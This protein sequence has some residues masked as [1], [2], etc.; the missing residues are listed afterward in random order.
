MAKWY[1]EQVKKYS[2]SA[3]G[4]VT[5]S[6]TG[7]TEKRAEKRSAPET[8]EAEQAGNK[9]QRRSRQSVRVP[10]DDEEEEEEEEEEEQ[11]NDDDDA[12]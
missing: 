10:D 1:L 8:P 2:L 7:A 11:V 9:R 12:E 6:G 5:K 3:P 4:K